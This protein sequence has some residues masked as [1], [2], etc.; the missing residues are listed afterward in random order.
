MPW[1][2]KGTIPTHP[3]LTQVTK[4]SLALGG[5]NITEDWIKI[6]VPGLTEATAYATVGALATALIATNTYFKAGDQLTFVYGNESDSGIIV[7]VSSIVLNPSSTE[8]LT[9][10]QG[11]A[12][13]LTFEPQGGLSFGAAILSRE[14]DNGEHLRSNSFLIGYT[15]FTGEAP[16]DADSKAAAIASYRASAA[17]NSDWAEESIQ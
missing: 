10:V 12:D 11:A 8:A 16:Y 17:S 6:S 4:G 3:V 2:E 9:R 13:E 7:S 14:G 1:F 15:G 5:L